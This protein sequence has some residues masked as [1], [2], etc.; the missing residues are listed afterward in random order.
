MIGRGQRMNRFSPPSSLISSGPGRQEQV[1]RVAEHHLVPERLH[2]TRLERL[3]RAA[4]GQRHERGRRHVA[5]RQ[6][7]RAR[8]GAGTRVAAGSRMRGR[9]APILGVRATAAAGGRSSARQDG[10]V[11]G[12]RGQARCP[13]PGERSW[14]ASVAAGHGDLRSVGSL[15]AVKAI[16]RS[17]ARADGAGR[18]G[19]ARDSA[20]AATQPSAHDSPSAHVQPSANT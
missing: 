9:T 3:D 18:P 2:V 11:G 17:H 10:P 14:P 19:D 8:A 5:V 20:S 13:R 15:S 6:V 16:S 7:Q 4:R 1:E 12:R